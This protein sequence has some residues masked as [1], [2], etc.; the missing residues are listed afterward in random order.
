M[1][2]S[3]RVA[4][5]GLVLLCAA[6][7]APPPAGFPRE[8]FGACPFECCQYGRWTSRDATVARVARDRRSGEAFR[9]ARGEA[10][11]ALTGLV[12]TLRP[13]HARAAAGLRLEGVTIE[14]GQDVLVLRP[15]GE[16]LFKIWIADRV[17]EA[18]LLPVSE[19]PFRL[20]SEP[21]IAWWVQI[22]NRQGLVGWTD[23]A[24]RFE[25]PD[26]CG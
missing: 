17:L 14:A 7:A 18:Q 6:A 8:E 11:D 26:R 5:T 16:G 15:V 1:R 24:D 22:R 2:P 4:L 25:G 19:A 23:Q 20:L 13:G 21:V 10:V 3:A 12:V 9:V